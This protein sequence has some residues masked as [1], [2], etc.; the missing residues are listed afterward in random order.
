MIDGVNTLKLFL[1]L[2]ST[3]LLV[4]G[5]LEAFKQY[6]V[7]INLYITLGALVALNIALILGLTIGLSLLY[8]RD[9][10]RGA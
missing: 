2:L 10:R 1:V 9:K 6:T 3:L 8:H 5:L 7:M 4:F